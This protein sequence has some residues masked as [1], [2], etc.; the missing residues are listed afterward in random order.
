[1]NL[2]CAEPSTIGLLGTMVF[3][4]WM[5]ASILVP[6]LSDMYGRKYFFLGFMIM[7]NLAITALFWIQNV[8]T[9][10]IALFMLGFSGVG[11][12]PILYI[13]LMELLS[14]DQ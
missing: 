6:R 7:Q 4:G 10:Y 12:S 2:T 9:A 3:L 11:R 13:Y 5:L 8:K 14:A 1:M